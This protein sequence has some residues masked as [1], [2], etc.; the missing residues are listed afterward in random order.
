MAKPRKGVKVLASVSRQWRKIVAE[1]DHP[2]TQIDVVL[3]SDLDSVAAA[4]ALRTVL[5][6]VEEKW[7]HAHP[8]LTPDGGDWF[9][10]EWDVTPVPE[11]ALLDGGRKSDAGEDIFQAADELTADGISGRLDLYERPEAPFPPV[12]VGAIEARVQLTGKPIDHS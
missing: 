12:G 8:G 6:R 2:D 11:G 5:R 4:G 7:Q 9:M 10:G 1:A 3:I